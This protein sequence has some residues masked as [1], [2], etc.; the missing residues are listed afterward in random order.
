[1]RGELDEW[2]EL[3]GLAEGGDA[4]IRATVGGDELLFPDGAGACSDVPSE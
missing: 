2:C 3:V 4:L 1:M